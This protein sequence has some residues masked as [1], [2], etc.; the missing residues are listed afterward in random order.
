MP[1]SLN[2]YKF[3][4]LE[5]NYNKIFRKNNNKAEV[6][7]NT[8]ISKA[9]KEKEEIKVADGYFLLHQLMKDEHSLLYLDSMIMVSKTIQNFEYLSKAHLYKGNYYY[10]KGEY[11][12]SLT[13][14][15]IARDFSKNDRSAYDIFNFNIG[16]LKI[17]LEHYQE[18][19]Q[20]FLD[21]KQSLKERHLTNTINNVRCLYALALVYNKVHDINN[22]NKY[23]KLG[24]QSDKINKDDRLYA[25]FL[26]V[27]GIN[28]YYQQNY[29][30]SIQT[31]SEVSYLLKKH[32]YKSLQNLALSDC[33]LGKSLMKVNRKEFLDKFK[34]VDSIIIET[35]NG[36]P[37]LRDI[38]PIYIDYY[39]KQGNKD[40]QLYFVEH[41]L[42]FDSI[43]Y[44]KT[45]IL[46][47]EINKKYDTPLLLKEKE[48]LISDLHARNYTLFWILGI[49]DVLIAS[50]SIVYVQNRKNV[51][52]YKNMG[53]ESSSSIDL[54]ENPISPEIINVK[55]EKSKNELSDGQLQELSDK[56]EQFEKGKL[57]LDKNI[58][59]DILSREFNTNRAYLSKSVN[60]LKGLSFPQYLNQLKIN[61]II[62]ELKR[63][64]K[65]QK[66]TIA[67]IADEAGFNNSES[68]LNAFKKIAGT[69]PSYFIK[70][71]QENERL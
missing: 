47:N 61:Y 18:A 53:E 66:L 34:T 70:T 69:L 27:T 22:S 29:E 26:L 24:L 20:L 57:F 32:S 25:N 3:E 31:L 16:L 8:F 48:D 50:L 49:G 35:K 64:N 1:D 28:E 65:L 58:N 7:A 37:E 63:N 10:A 23:V 71:L 13:N 17:E 39:K 54:I 43:M 42:I 52:H 9:K 21:Y 67:A 2:D 41:L 56:L 36:S 68:F 19:I 44:K 30:K 38:Y 4:Q 11:P 5:I 14:Y 62:E 12:K 51:K 60:T 59:L 55:V 46:S 45:H 40:R 15:L 6:Y 33:F